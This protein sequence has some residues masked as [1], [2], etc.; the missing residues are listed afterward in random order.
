MS[1]ERQHGKIIFTCDDGKCHESL[2][3]DTRNF[4]E[5]LEML[6][7]EEWKTYKNKDGSYTHICPTCDNG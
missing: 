5:A 1:L 6:K 4:D 2:D 7:S 3:T